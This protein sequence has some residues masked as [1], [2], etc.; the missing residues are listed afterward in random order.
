[1]A[2]RPLPARERTVLALSGCL[3][4]G[5]SPQV[6]SHRETHSFSDLSGR[7][8]EA[9]RL[10]PGRGLRGT[11]PPVNP[12]G[13]CRS[14]GRRV[15]M[16]GQRPH[17]RQKPGHTIQHRRHGC[18]PPS[19]NRDHPEGPEGPERVGSA[20][21]GEAAGGRGRPEPAGKAAPLGSAT[22]ARPRALGPRA[23]PRHELTG[24]QPRRASR[25]P[26]SRRGRSRQRAPRTATRERTHRQRRR[27]VER[28]SRFGYRACS[29]S[30]C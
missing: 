4:G 29:R 28:P 11:P 25:P 24:R 2:R 19:S 23:G 5:L 10:D 17:D 12:S 18:N 9:R 30:R 16:A 20:T 21:R 7:S 8:C 6:D 22:R 13:I 1:M 27:R 15:Y 26:H 14:S 3:D